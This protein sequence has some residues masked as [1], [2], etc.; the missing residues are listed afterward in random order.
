MEMN[1]PW[2]LHTYGLWLRHHAELGEPGKLLTA[3]ERE[4]S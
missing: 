1:E 2:N 3:N 4:Q